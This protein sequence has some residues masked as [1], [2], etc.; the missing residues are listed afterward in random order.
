VGKFQRKRGHLEGLGM[1]GWGWG[2][3]IKIDLKE[4]GWKEVDWIDLAKDRDD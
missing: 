1:G 3:S 4:I 2:G